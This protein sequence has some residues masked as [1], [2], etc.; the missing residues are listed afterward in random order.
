M[1]IIS[2]KCH[3]GNVLDTIYD[4][5][6][7]ARRVA[8]KDACTHN[9]ADVLAVDAVGGIAMMKGCKKFDYLDDTSVSTCGTHQ[10]R[11]RL[12]TK[13]RKKHGGG[14]RA[15]RMIG[16]TIEAR[17]CADPGG[18]VELLDVACLRY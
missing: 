8:R 12:H 17:I 15:N 14:R 10:I 16:R 13:Q 5:Q 11:Q 7:R 18:C 4:C 1:A 2:S 6:F 9:G 3:Y